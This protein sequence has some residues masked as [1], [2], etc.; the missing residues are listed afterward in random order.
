[1]KRIFLTIAMLLWAASAH[2]A[3]WYVDNAA[4][5]SNN[6]TSWAN[7][8]TNITNASGLAAGD[9]VYISGGSSS[10]SY[11][12]SSWAPASG[13]SGNP[14]T[15][16]AGQDTGHN[17]T[18]ILNGGSYCFGNGFHD[19]TF[20]GNYGG[21]MHIQVQNCSNQ[22]WQPTGSIGNVKFKY[23][24]FPSN[25]G[26]FWFNQIGTVNGL[27]WDH[28]YIK[29]VDAYPSDKTNTWWA[30]YGSTWDS[31]SIHDCEIHYPVKSSD[32]GY[33]D[34]VVQW[35]SGLTAYN[36]KFIADYT[37]YVELPTFGRFSVK[38]ELQQDIQ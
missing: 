25:T 27:E 23:I 18:V 17:G 20:D 4:T 1:M 2:A 29:K 10:K 24:S 3:I 30:M 38:S 28:C 12:I 5:G 36:N 35:A 19:V 9:T 7:A 33:G 14:I 6:G 37:T 31:N 34:D 8:W 21:S 22:V 32:P 15:W 13:S 16:R 26:G 11:S